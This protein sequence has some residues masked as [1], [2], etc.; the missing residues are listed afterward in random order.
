M[1]VVKPGDQVTQHSDDIVIYQLKF[2]DWSVD[3]ENPDD[4]NARLS[5]VAVRGELVNVRVLPY[6]MGSKVQEVRVVSPLKKVSK[7]EIVRIVKS[8]SASAKAEDATETRRR[9]FFVTI[10]V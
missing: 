7:C 2:D 8:R 10:V 4:K 9:S 6:R 5:A 1:I 3:I